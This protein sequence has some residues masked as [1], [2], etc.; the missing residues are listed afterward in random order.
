MVEK[1]KFKLEGLTDDEMRNH[2]DSKSLSIAKNLI[3]TIED[4]SRNFTYNFIV[5][6]IQ[7]NGGTDL[8][9]RA[10]VQQINRRVRQR[11]SG[12]NVQDAK[13][14]EDPGVKYIVDYHGLIEDTFEGKW[15][16]IEQGAFVEAKRRYKEETEISLSQIQNAFNYLLAEMRS[17]LRKFPEIN[18]KILLD[19]MT[20]EDCFK[21]NDLFKIYELDDKFGNIA[22]AGGSQSLGSARKAPST[23]GR[24]ES[25]T[26]D[27]DFSMSMDSDEEHDNSSEMATAGTKQ[28]QRRKTKK[29][30]GI[31]N[32]NQVPDESFYLD[33]QQFD[34]QSA[35]SVEDID[36]ITQSF[37]S[38]YREEKGE[39]DV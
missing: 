35:I 20:V 34:D 27:F 25:S 26:A 11:V 28:Q 6:Q 29:A 33:M 1:Q 17:L 38:S 22:G 8:A 32:F 24:Q 16:K 19:K 4:E 37:G 14:D 7:T 10:L 30:Q 21:T 23:I 15:S 12:E 9:N 31:K 2:D 18:D 39:V 13:T 5:S 36:L 3:D